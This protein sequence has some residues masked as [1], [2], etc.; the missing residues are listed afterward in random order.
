MNEVFRHAHRVTYAECT[1]GNHVYYARYLDLLEAARGELFR[2]AGIPFAALQG[3]G[4]ILPVVG[5]A[6]EYSGAARYDDVVQ[7]EVWATRVHRV[8]VEFAYR[9]VGPDGRV[10]VSG[11][12]RH[13]CTDLSDKPVRVP[14]ALVEALRRWTVPA[15]SGVHP[16]GVASPGG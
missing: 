16:G 12:T 11:E 3:Q 8:R 9:V 13:A 7:V 1:V 10:L 14:A 2:A 4:V 6:L 5:V 15:A